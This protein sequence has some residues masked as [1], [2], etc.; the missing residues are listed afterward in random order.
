[1]YRGVGQAHGDRETV[2]PKFPKFPHHKTLLALTNMG[3]QQ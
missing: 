1:M 3:K 2:S